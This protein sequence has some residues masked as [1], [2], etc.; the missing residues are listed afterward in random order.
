MNKVHLNKVYLGDMVNASLSSSLVK[1]NA[2]A[3]AVPEQLTDVEQLTELN[4]L[5]ATGAKP[6]RP[7]TRIRPNLSDIE[8]SF[9]VSN[10]KIMGR[11]SLAHILHMTVYQLTRSYNRYKHNPIHLA[12]VTIITDTSRWMDKDTERKVYASDDLNNTDDPITY[13]E[14]LRVSKEEQLKEANRDI[15]IYEKYPSAGIEERIGKRSKYAERPVPNTTEELTSFLI[16]TRTKYSRGERV[17]TSFPINLYRYSKQSNKQ[18]RGRKTN[19]KSLLVPTTL[20][21]YF[22]KDIPVSRSNIP[23]IMHVMNTPSTISRYLSI[24]TKLYVQGNLLVVRGTSTTSFNMY[25]PVPYLHDW[26]LQTLKG[27]V[28]V[29]YGNNEVVYDYLPLDV[30]HVVYLPFHVIRPHIKQR[31]FCSPIF[32]NSNN[33]SLRYR[34]DVRRLKS[35]TKKITKRPTVMYA[36][37]CAQCDSILTEHT[38]THCEHLRVLATYDK[39]QS[40]KFR[41]L[42]FN[43]SDK[44]LLD[45]KAKHFNKYGSLYHNDINYVNTIRQVLTVY[46]E[47]ESSD[48]ALFPYKY[49]ETLRKAIPKSFGI[50]S[51]RKLDYNQV[52]ASIAFPVSNLPQEPTY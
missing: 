3:L 25:K 29:N 28:T 22:T 43:V 24:P 45:T 37:V 17:N 10:Y 42:K 1:D 7:T 2:E 26:F 4:K 35:I 11:E 39:I 38:S 8:I 21:T 9:L 20:G 49:S 50:Y 23:M 47:E 5:K 33:N 40:C 6:S 48:F 14:L 52:P 46:K 13:K 41:P 18:S 36:V 27:E 44:S 31:A 12:P 16:G 51:L 15:S 32:D 19:T 30:T 34:G